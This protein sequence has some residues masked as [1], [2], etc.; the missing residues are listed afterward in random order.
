MIS[1]ETKAIISAS[2]AVL[3]WSTVATA[4][5]LALENLTHFELL[6]IASFTSLLIFTI[7]LTFQHRWR[8]L[9][10]LSL[11]NWIYFALLGLLNP[12]LYY[13]V[14]FKSYSL[15]PAQIAQPINYMWPVVLTVLLAVFAHRKIPNRKYVGLIISLGG[16][17]LI[18]LGS[19]RISQ[20]HLSGVG[21]FLAALSAV[22]WA[23]Y[24]MVTSKN[25]D[26]TDPTILL[27]LC[28]LF[29]TIYLFVMACFIRVHT[30]TATGLLSGMY[31]G[32][33]EMGVPFVAFGYAIR[34]TEN[35]VLINQ[36]C[37][38][39]PFMSLFFISVVLHESI[40]ITTYLGL[41]L[42]VLGII[43]NKYSIKSKH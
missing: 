31:V 24:W 37:Y 28:F 19:N 27:F 29:G 3:S 7:I 26:K 8:A 33:F 1:N 25:K 14:L 36:M 30:L 23:L 6:L 10:D 5:K 20:S 43:F 34:K 4:F 41:G 21:F 39:S 38:I 32:C 16:V 18:S 42:I 12:V 22:L 11:N 9:T 40:V 35:P 15:L 17:F 13:L 2:L